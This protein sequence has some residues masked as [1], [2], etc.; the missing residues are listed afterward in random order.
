MLKVS[1]KGYSVHQHTAQLTRDEE[2]ERRVRSLLNKI[3]PEN[4]KTIVERLALIELY[5]AEELEFVIRIIF[6]KALAEPHYCETYADMVFALR[7]RYPEFPAEAEDQKPT[8]FTRVLLNTCQNEFESLPS[9]FEATEEER[10]LHSTEELNLEMK[11][12]KDKMLANMKFIGNLFLRQLLAVKVIGQVVHDLVGLKE[13]LPEEHMIECVCE[14]LRSIGFT[15]DNTQHGKALMSQF[16]N[17]LM[18]LKRTVGHDGR[19]SFSKRIQFQ[20][21]DLL[22]LRG[23][24][25]QEK[26]F[27]DQAK[28]KQEIR[29]DAVKEAK[30]QATKGGPEVVFGTQV[31]GM[32]PTYIDDTKNPKPGRRGPEPVKQTFDQ[33]YVKRVF[34]YYAEERNADSLEHEWNRAQPNP[35]EAVQ[36]VAWLL[37]IGFVDVQKEDVVAETV[38]HLVMRHA[39][40]WDTLREALQPQLEGLEDMM[41]DVPTA[42][43]FVHSLLSRLLAGRSFNASVLRPLYRL[44]EAPEGGIFVFGLLRG[45]VRKLRDR[46]GADVARKA[47]ELPELSELLCKAKRCEPSELKRHLQDVL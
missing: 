28:T 2:I 44:C 36:G 11:R 21:Q 17:R 15:L 35:R 47:I 16:A 27:R 19:L 1:E 24:S 46:S 12:R 23:N 43:I 13:A 5:K 3:C 6:T 39:V 45:A 41:F 38:T 8:T 10:K 7:T 40:S 31:A 20:I 22:D 9:T 30:I 25:W 34:Q 14:L 42:D 32:R 33:A 18:D 4:L 29:M 37:E 26:L